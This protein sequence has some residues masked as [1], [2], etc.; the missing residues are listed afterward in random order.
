MLPSSM[1]KLAVA[2]VVLRQDHR[3]R[4][5]QSWDW[6]PGASLAAPS[7]AWWGKEVGASFS[8]PYLLPDDSLGSAA[9]FLGIWCESSVQPPTAS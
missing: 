8:Q 5:Q 9:I 3:D 1:W 7:V 4:E 2:A 6:E